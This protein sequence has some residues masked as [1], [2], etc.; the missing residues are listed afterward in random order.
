MERKPYPLIK[1]VKSEGGF[2]VYL[3]AISHSKV[4]EAYTK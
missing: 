2:E 1:D 4:P 3:I